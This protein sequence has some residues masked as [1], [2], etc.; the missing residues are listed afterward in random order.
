MHCFQARRIILS[1]FLLT[2]Y[3]M[4][5]I[6]SGLFFTSSDCIAHKDL[7]SSQLTMKYYPSKLNNTENPKDLTRDSCR[8]VR[9]SVCNISQAQVINYDCFTWI[10]RITA[11]CQY[12]PSN[13]I[14]LRQLDELC[15]NRTF[16]QMTYQLNDTAVQ[17]LEVLC[18]G[19]LM[20]PND[21]TSQN[22]SICDVILMIPIFSRDMP[23]LISDY[24][25]EALNSVIKQK[26]SN[27]SDAFY[28]CHHNNH[29]YWRQ[30]KCRLS[31]LQCKNNESAV[32]FSCSHMSYNCD[33]LNLSSISQRVNSTI[34]LEGVN[35]KKYSIHL[36]DFGNAIQP[37]NYVT[38]SIQ[39]GENSILK[40][41]LLLNATGPIYLCTLL[42]DLFRE[43]EHLN[44]SS[45]IHQEVSSVQPVKKELR[46]EPVNRVRHKRNSEMQTTGLYSSMSSQ[47]L[48]PRNLQIVPLSFGSFNISWIPARRNERF[49]THY[50]LILFN[51]NEL[52]ER[53]LTI[54]LE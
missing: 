22:S 18:I 12:I 35:K 7:N 37:P 51:L 26:C 39:K 47:L 44:G 48:P 32:Y 1:H 36:P 30:Q 25:N 29:S 4:M 45:N 19:K 34:T 31:K 11:P 50:E 54:A 3:T 49:I 43:Y 40:Q 24:L 20:P 52:S 41:E 14:I 16:C 13:N 15:S 10:N 38:S 53:L 33:K 28:Y 42:N 2:F 21:K 5:L 17:Q 9:F 46:I 8:T 27:T 23:D 6:N